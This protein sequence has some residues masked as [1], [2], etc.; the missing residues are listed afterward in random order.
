LPGKVGVRISGG[1]KVF[2]LSHRDDADGLA[3]AALVRCATRCRFALAGYEDL[4]K[5]LAGAPRGMDWVI[6]TDLGLGENQQVIPGLRAIAERILYVDHHP[7]SQRTRSALRRARAIICHSIEECTSVLVWDSFRKQ[8]PEEA[9][10]LAAYGALTD[11]P[12]SGRLTREVLL[13]TSWNKD[14]YEAHLLALALSSH[15]CT[16]VLREETVKK[17]AA[18]QLPHQ[19][20]AIRRIADQQAAG[21][22][23]IQKQ[24]YSQAEVRGRVAIARAGRLALGTSAEL[25]LGVPKVD[26]SLVHHTIGSQSH[27]RVSVRGTG[28]HRQHLGKVMQRLARKVG[29][30]GGGHAI[31]AGAVVPTS[32][33]REFLGLFVRRMRRS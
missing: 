3:S 9:I 29:G 16:K 30:S 17:L 12:V 4:E 2:C 6:V 1:S 32:R 5:V 19:I 14:A 7:L 21:M 31:A 33:F 11:P 13:K 26:A 18:L 24:L 10:N 27:T 8:L 22:A 23:R 25:L 20:P 15:R 28:E